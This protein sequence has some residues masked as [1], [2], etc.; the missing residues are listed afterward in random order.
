MAIS[1]LHPI[2]PSTVTTAE[3]E[4]KA[5]WIVRKLVGTMTGRMVFSAYETLRAS[6]NVVCLSPWGDSNPL[7]L[8][9]IRFRDLIV[10]A[11]VV[12]TAGTASAVLVASPVMAPVV[13]EIYS[14]VGDSIIVQLG[15]QAGFDVVTKP[16][17]ELV[18]GG[19][20]KHSIPSHSGL[21]VTTGVKT[22]LI[23]L[24]YY[25]T[26]KDAAIGYFRASDHTD[27]DLFSS[28]K[29]YLSI[30]KGWMSPYM[31]ASHRRPVIPRSVQPD[32]VFV[33]SPFVPG[34]YRVAQTLLTHSAFVIQL[35][36]IPA[37]DPNFSENEKQ[38]VFADFFHQK[39]S[40]GPDAKP[41]TPSLDV[42]P[43]TAEQDN[44]SKRLS[45]SYK[46]Q[47]S[48]YATQA[49]ASVSDFFHRPKTPTT[50]TPA[51]APSSS[52]ASIASAPAPAPDVSTTPAAAEVDPTIPPVVA[53]EPKLRRM[54]VVV[55]GI[56]PHRAG[57]WTSS[58]RPG[59][60]VMYYAIM[61]GC[62]A[63]VLPLLPGSPLVAWH[64][65]T[66]GQ[67]Q[68]LEG[69]ISGPKFKV[70]AQRLYQ[71]VDLCIDWERVVPDDQLEEAEAETPLE[72]KRKLAVRRAIEA[73]LAGAVQSDC[74]E[75]RKE[76]DADRAGI[77]FFR[78]P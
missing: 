30:E 75:V 73:L 77:A 60:S 42:K 66:L 4:Q 23:T 22:L 69:G 70:I 10:H 8:P 74:K 15:V 7:I 9:N 13:S 39:K 59:E 53:A 17:Y 14:V 35:S 31:F 29:D 68:K 2:D 49:S 54:V 26:M 45:G 12:G 43:S 36:D 5:T 46:D 1:A 21:L 34:D 25:H 40:P 27:T 58:E 78:I 41:D 57:L 38:G 33:H 71:Y 24:K 62:P 28:V 20:V 52:I 16:A 50:T 19:V 64:A 56:R 11:I 76:V 44:K 65:N 47:L 55:L 72:E 61:N 67:L 18:V 32:V 51:Q 6:T 63:V 48:A 3:D 37:P